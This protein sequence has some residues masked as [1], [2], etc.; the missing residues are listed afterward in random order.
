[1]QN[2]NYYSSIVEAYFRRHLQKPLAACLAGL[3]LFY[4]LLITFPGHYH[5]INPSLLD[6]SWVYAINYLPNS[7]YL[8]GKDVVFTY[9]PLSYLM[10]PRHIG[11]NIEQSLVFMLF[12][13][14]LFA[15]ILFIYFRVTKYKTQFYLFALCYSITYALSLSD[16]VLSL[17]YEYYLLTIF[18]LLC[19]L[20]SR[21]NTPQ[22]FA[23]VVTGALAPVF[24]LIKFS[25][26][27]NCLIALVV[28]SITWRL[29]FAK[30]ANRAI[31]FTYLSLISA[32]TIL[33]FAYFKSINNFYLWIYGSWEVAKGYG[34][35]MSLVINSI[36][37]SRGVLLLAVVIVAALILL[38]KRTQAGYLI[39]IALGDL[40]ISFR[41][42][43]IRQQMPF[44][45]LYLAVIS[46]ICLACREKKTAYKYGWC[47]AIVCIIS[48]YPLSY[49]G[50]TLNNVARILDTTQ[51][52]QN[53]RKL[54]KIDT[55]VKNVD[56]ATE[57]N[58]KEF[59]LPEDLVQH[60]QKSVGAK[61][62]TLPDCIGY[63]AANHLNFDPIPV[64]QLYSVYTPYLDKLCADHFTLQTAPQF[65]I[66]GPTA[67]LRFSFDE[68]DGR[69]PVLESPLTTLALLRNYELYKIYKN[70]EIMLLQKR[71]HIRQI[72]F[73]AI[74]DHQYKTNQWISVPKSSSLMLSS[75]KLRPK[76]FLYFISKL[77]QL[78]EIDLQ[79]YSNENIYSRYRI[80]Y[81][82]LSSGLLL[83]CC[84]R[85]VL[86]F[87]K[88]FN[89]ENP[90]PVRQ[91]NISGPGSNLFYPEIEISW[92]EL[93]FS[94]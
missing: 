10:I 80:V 27:F 8:F 58:Y 94:P 89:G 39:F 90:N 32:L 3:C 24:M 2:Y 73:K 79:M 50:I 70:A 54:L 18:L 65:I 35:S 11:S 12:I 55:T 47:F 76:P 14:I 60:I 34:D 43:F 26:G 75:I 22:I 78:P 19:Y 16:N 33:V 53:I 77:Y 69:N 59:L 62:A 46:I 30:Q 31:I 74:A 4:L 41:H 7:N 6:E 64:L 20:P 36:S 81:P 87:S 21:C 44:F 84:P 61:V 66:W 15:F 23:G 68:I 38:W 88:L 17:W 91:I 40:F 63:T 28:A 13:H 83:N 5:A 45:L 25:L 42:S 29:E 9:G 49:A 48:L 51:G 37:V 52:Q 72:S 82:N 86:E 71:K 56:I 67:D 92:T 57:K 93:I 85:N 1:M